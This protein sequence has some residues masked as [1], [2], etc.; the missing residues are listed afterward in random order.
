MIA[1]YRELWTPIWRLNIWELG[2]NEERLA[3]DHHI[4]FHHSVDVNDKAPSARR[5]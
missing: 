3:P 1:R 5:I 2:E 4:S